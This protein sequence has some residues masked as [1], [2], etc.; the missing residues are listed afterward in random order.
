MK[1]RMTPK[2]EG[3]ANRI[4]EKHMKNFEEITVITDAVYA[5]G[6]AVAAILSI[7]KKKPKGNIRGGNRRERKLKKKM[8]ELRRLTARAGYRAV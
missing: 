6:K 1:V 8:K 7:T 4:I 5:M 3:S 2:V